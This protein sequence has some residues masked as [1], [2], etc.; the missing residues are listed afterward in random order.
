[1]MRVA[2]IDGPLPADY[3]RC[4]A[5]RPGNVAC[6]VDSPAG[7]HAAA[8]AHAIGSLAPDARLISIPVFPALLSARTADLVAA[9]RRASESEADIVHCSLGFAR[10]DAAV[11]QAVAAL[12]GRIVV[13]SAPARGGPVWPAALETVIAVQGDARC[14]VDQWSNLGLPGADYGACPSLAISAEVAGASIAAAHLTGHIAR[15]GVRSTT[16]ARAFLDTQAAFV[17]RERRNPALPGRHS[18]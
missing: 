9:L 17:G 4:I 2:L 8:I 10:Y 5:F 13:A 12:S 11:A 6:V 3:P 16:D 1:M 14:T 18:T 15:K 7:Q